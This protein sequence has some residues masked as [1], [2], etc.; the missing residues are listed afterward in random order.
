[1]LNSINKLIQ[2]SPEKYITIG[3]LFYQGITDHDFLHISLGGLNE[4]D[5]S[6][7]YNLFGDPST[8]Y[9]L[10][11]LVN[12]LTDVNTLVYRASASKMRRGGIG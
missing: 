5:E 7:Y 11:K 3:D 4:N 12:T 1:M 9:N 2:K 10:C 8:K 6:Y